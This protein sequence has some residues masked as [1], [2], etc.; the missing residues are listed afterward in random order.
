MDNNRLE[1]ASAASLEEPDGLPIPDELQDKLEHYE[2]WLQKTYPNSQGLKFSAINLIAETILLLQQV[3]P[4]IS[5]TTDV[6]IDEETGK[7]EGTG[8][9]EVL[10][11]WKRNGR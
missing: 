9:P 4:S 2:Q 7:I 1:I 6:D 11:I 5:N 8:E 3:P 10:L